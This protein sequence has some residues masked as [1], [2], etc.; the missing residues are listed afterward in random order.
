MCTMSEL[1]HKT[2]TDIQLSFTDY[3]RLFHLMLRLHV[4][5]TSN[6]RIISFNVTIACKSTLNERIITFNGVISFKVVT[7]HD[8][9]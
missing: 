6:E 9:L 3:E 1:R 7:K 5:S 8:G 2:T 4:A